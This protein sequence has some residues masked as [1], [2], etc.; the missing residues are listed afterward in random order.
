MDRDLTFDVRRFRSAE[1]EYSEAQKKR[2]EWI[3]KEMHAQRRLMSLLQLIAD[4]A[5]ETNEDLPADI[6]KMALNHLP[7]QGVSNA[8][9]RHLQG[10]AQRVA[11]PPPPQL[12]L[13]VETAAESELPTNNKTEFVRQFV[14]RNSVNGVT[15]A[16]VKKAATAAGIKGLNSNFPHV[17]LWKLKTAG[18]L[19]EQGGRY[20]AA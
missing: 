10:L 16:E 18:K 7:N 12:A 19:K 4:R 9:L 11:E 6:L 15:P 3:D 8:V 17:I 20:F 13:P 5:Q 1:R 2:E 14:K